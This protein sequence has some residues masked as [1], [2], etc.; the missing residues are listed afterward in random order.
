MGHHMTA[1]DNDP[2]MLAR[3]TTAE[4][5]CGDLFELELGRRFDVAIAGSHLVN[6][7][8]SARRKRLLAMCAQHVRD[9]GLAL[10]E[11]Y[12]QGWARSPEDVGAALGPVDVS[13][14]IESVGSDSCKG[15]R[16]SPRSKD[17]A[18]AF[19]SSSRRPP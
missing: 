13:V 16:V 10:V 18:A 8:D 1:V 3:V 12:D 7:L 19:Q 15:G 4:V 11:R 5:V 14:T 9:G 2:A 17:L 6:S